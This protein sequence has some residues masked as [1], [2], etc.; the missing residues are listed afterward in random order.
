MV[1][2]T[3]RLLTIVFVLLAGCVPKSCGDRACAEGKSCAES[4]ECSARTIA[5]GDGPWRC[6]AG[7]DDECAASEVCKE[8]GQCL[9]SE[10]GT[11]EDAAGLE[12]TRC[13]DSA[14]C[15]KAGRC[16]PSGQGFC[17]ALD[18]DLCRASDHCGEQ[19]LCHAY[20]PPLL[21]SKTV[22]RSCR[23]KSDADCSASTDC[24][25]LGHCGMRD[26]MMGPGL[27]EATEAKHC[28]ESTLC[29]TEGACDWIEPGKIGRGR[30]VFVAESN[31]ECEA[32][33]G[34]RIRGTCALVPKGSQ[35]GPMQ[36]S[37]AKAEHCE[38][39]EDCLTGKR[40]CNFS[41]ASYK[42]KTIPGG[43]CY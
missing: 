38:Q 42:G 30:C 9:A 21:G 29:E 3:R 32:S 43:S 4:G 28:E 6:Y 26:R 15:K 12:S 8:E 5:A 31:E 7:S 10:V 22:M 40:G 20:D 35:K 2:P 25:K 11:C 27:C 39:S 19:G 24:T 37:P 16:A 18:D 14:E 17:A 23:A 1:L 41:P 34:C 13:L 36:C 33:A